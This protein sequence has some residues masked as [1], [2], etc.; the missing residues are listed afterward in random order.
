VPLAALLPG[1]ASEDEAVTWHVG[2]IEVYLEGPPLHL[3]ELRVD[4]QPATLGRSPI[5]RK[6]AVFE[7]AW[8]RLRIEPVTW[9]GG[10][11]LFA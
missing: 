2:G 10:H 6:P 4:E 9:M 7:A 11:P 3:V 8:T 5:L 1:I